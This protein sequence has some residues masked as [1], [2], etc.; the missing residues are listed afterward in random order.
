MRALPSIKPSKGFGHIL[1]LVL[2]GLIPILAYVLVKIDFVP[3]ALALVLLSKWRMFAVKP[4]YWPANLRA[5]AVDLMVGMSLV[6]F[7]APHGGNAVS[8]FWQLVWVVAYIVWL[9]AI[10]P[11]SS[12]LMVSIQAFV[13]QTLALT[14]LF[15]A[16]GDVSAW[17]LVISVWSISYLAARHFF[18]SFDE[19]NSPLY[20]YTWGYF[21]ASLAWVLAHWL[22][23]YGFLAQ[24]ALLLSIIGFGCASLYYLDET[25]KLSTLWRRQIIF[26][27][28]AVIVVLL[29]FS[30]WGDKAYPKY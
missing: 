23:Y 9:L 27:M 17:I 15:I 22:I 7:M 3:V 30:G 26:V 13:A 21:S 24:A 18:T 11:R 2:T 1:H 19:P 28:I 12:T 4:R 20:A 16:W 10:K 5:N 8:S 6:Y 25:D 29:V 14:A